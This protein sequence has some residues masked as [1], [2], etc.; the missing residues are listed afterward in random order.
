[1]KNIAGIKRENRF[2]PNHTGND[3]AIFELTRQQLESKGYKV[4]VYSED[5]FCADRLEHEI[6][7]DMAR[8]KQTV[9]KL[10]RCEDQ[11]ALVINSGYGIENCYRANMTELLIKAAIPFPKSFIANTSDDASRDFE[12]LGSAVFWIKR[13]DFHAIH[14]EDVVP[15]YSIDEGNMMLKEFALR[16]IERAVISEHLAGDLIKFYGVRGTS[17]FHRFYPFDARHSKFGHEILNGPAN[18]I[19]FSDDEL[20]ILAN[21]AASILGV[22]VYGGDAII[23]ED[24]TIRIIDFNDWPSFAP[25]RNEAAKYIADTIDCRIARYKNQDATQSIKN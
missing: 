12:A 19:P 25:C 5:E 14:K 18:N 11:G 13:D 3:S 21:R 17:F 6:I 23:A 2:S 20:Q 4:R 15:A 7:F 10:K 8:D 24:G 22:Y 1:M 9:E 16:G